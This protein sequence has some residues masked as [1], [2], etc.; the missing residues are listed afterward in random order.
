MAEEVIKNDGS[1]EPF[2]AS[3]IRNSIAAAAKKTDLPEDRQ[4]E[5]VEDVTST[6]IQ[7]TEEKKEIETSK[8]RENIL[9]QLDSLEPSVSAAWRRYDQEKKGT[10]EI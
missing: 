5:V 3:K 10:G 9:G 2:D 6:I 7:I 8:I 4:K 1:K